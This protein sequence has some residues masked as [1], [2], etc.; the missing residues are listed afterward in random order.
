[1]KG[2]FS[3]S[4]VNQYLLKV[5]KDDFI[6]TRLMV[7]GEVFNKRHH[8]SGVIYFTLKDEHSSINCRISEKAGSSRSIED[9]MEIILSGRVSL[10]S[11]QA[12]CVIIA[13]SFEET[14]MGAVFRE[15]YRKKKSLEEKGYLDESVKRPIPRAKKIGIVT[16]EIG[17]VVHDIITV[18]KSRNPSV[19]LY[20][21]PASVQGESAVGEVI[22]GINFFN[23]KFPVDVIIF[24]RGGGSYEELNVFNDEEL[25]EVVANSKIPT[26]SAVGHETDIVLSDYAADRRAATPSQA[27][28]MAVEERKVLFGE[29]EEL[30]ERLISIF[31][32]CLKEKTIFLDELDKRLNLSFGKKLEL[33]KKFLLAL[34]RKLDICNPELM[35]VRQF[36]KLEE[37]S[38]SLN[39]SSRYY[40]SERFSSLEKLNSRLEI[41]YKET[42]AAAK[43]E[44][45]NI[46]GEPLQGVKDLSVGETVSL[47]FPDGV[48]FL[49]VKKIQEGF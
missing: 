35:L 25:C 9:G 21:Y 18:S 1:M 37:L 20:L 10:N 13:E 48:A 27:A 22:E 47:I 32:S 42:L 45:R 43:P 28:E 41:A 40:F 17:A 38:K 31:S 12:S 16:S 5:I 19:S 6:L 14:G 24:G 49:E 34:R 44:V 8:P 30:N 36:G 29:A 23:N 15:F 2:Y 3:V 39:F 4:D 7:K 11:H 46:E 33:D 26:I